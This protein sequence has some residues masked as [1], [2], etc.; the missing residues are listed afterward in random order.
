MRA[1]HQ[2]VVIFT[3]T[4][5]SFKP[6]ADLLCPADHDCRPNGWIERE[7]VILY[8]ASTIISICNPL[9]AMGVLGLT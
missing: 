1:V 5:D 9:I 7:K 3:L 4:L 8:P 6:M 2:S